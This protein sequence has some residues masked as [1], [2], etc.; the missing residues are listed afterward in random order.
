MP[1]FRFFAEKY[2]WPLFQTLCIISRDNKYYLQGSFKQKATPSLLVHRGGLRN[3][4]DMGTR[5]LVQDH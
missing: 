2:P 1:L 4:P 5:V 3:L